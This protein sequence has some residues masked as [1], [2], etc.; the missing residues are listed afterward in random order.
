MLVLS[1]KQDDEILIGDNVCIKVVSVSG[2]KVR[3]G[4]MAPADVAIRRGELDFFRNSDDRIR[5]AGNVRTV[6]FRI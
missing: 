3:L 5:N 6:D 4:I 1:R 2:N